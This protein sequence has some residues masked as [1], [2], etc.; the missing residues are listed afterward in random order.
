MTSFVCGLL[1]CCLCSLFP[2][3][4]CQFVLWDESPPYP[5]VSPGSTP[6]APAS[7]AT[8]PGHFVSW[9]LLPD[10]SNNNTTCTWASVADDV[11]ST[12]YLLTSVAVWEAQTG[13][14][15]AAAGPV[16]AINASGPGVLE[17]ATA[18]TSN[19]GL[20]IPA[21]DGHNGTYTVSTRDLVEALTKAALQHPGSEVGTPRVLCTVTVSD[22]V[23]GTITGSGAWQGLSPP[24]DIN[25]LVQCRAWA[26]YPVG[27]A[28]RPAAVAAPALDPLHF[29]G[30][31]WR[32]LSIDVWDGVQG[33]VEVTP[34]AYHCYQRVMQ[35]VAESTSQSL[36]LNVT[37]CM[38]LQNAVDAVFPN[39]ASSRQL[40]G[41][42]RAI[43]SSSTLSRLVKLRLL[44]P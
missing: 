18:T 38:V 4:W 22:G 39:S 8:R 15:L 1:L 2:N 29:S 30:A 36:Q 17:A 24:L 25:T 10:G 28:L 14:V 20:L 43:W 3:L 27:I 19:V 35:L 32:A 6:A 44:T 34:I 11:V 7:A 33:E 23:S 37:G 26:R 42:L 12:G 40:N 9:Q 16:R 5:Q 13:A 41:E 21:G 31:A